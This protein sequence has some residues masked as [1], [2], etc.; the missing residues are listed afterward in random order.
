VADFGP[1]VLL[2]ADGLFCD[3]VVAANLVWQEM[4][5]IP[6]TA[7]IFVQLL[8]GNG[9]LIAQADGP[10]LNLRPDFITVQPG[11]EITDRR[12]LTPAA[13]DTPSQLL[14]GL[15]DFTT[16]ERFTAV[17]GQQAPLADNAFRL[18]VQ[19]CP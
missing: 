6:P 4:G 16:G 12:L 19:A 7:S 13:T 1:Y 15:Y 10:P 18:P 9:R 11:W 5:P 14:V 2:E 17:D 8:D 3:G